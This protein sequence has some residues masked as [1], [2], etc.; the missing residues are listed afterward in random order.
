MDKSNRIYWLKLPVDFFQRPEMLMLA[1]Q[2]NGPS[3]L[4][5]YIRLLTMGAKT[6][7]YI[8]FSDSEPYT[9]DI[10]SV[11]FNMKKQIVE[12]AI[13]T[14]ERFHLIET[15][16]DKTIVIPQMSDFVGSESTW[17]EK[18]REQRKGK[19]KEKED[20]VLNL[21]RNCPVDIER[22]KE[23][24]KEIEI[25]LEKEREKEREKNAPDD[26]DALARDIKNYVVDNHKKVN[27]ETFVNYYAAR[28]WKAGSADVR[29]NWRRFVD[30]WDARQRERDQMA[31]VYKIAA[32]D[33]YQEP[34]IVPRAA[35]DP[36]EY[37]ARITGETPK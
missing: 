27:P 36:L 20:N 14:L 17:A 9:A 22:E 31:P 11:V 3:I 6:N 5:F 35:D 21:S 1:A 4:V 24:E 12:S 29:K 32:P 26:P 34:D 16:D 10:F 37:L 28:N 30:L 18:K 7:G 2:D 15:L 23:K 19:V 13:V 25:D 33:V 8:R